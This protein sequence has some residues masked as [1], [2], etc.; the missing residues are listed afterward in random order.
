M[1]AR[2]R[3][4]HT[5]PWDL[6]PGDWCWNH[7][8][9][10]GK[11]EGPAERWLLYHSPNPHVRAFGMLDSRWTVTGDG[12]AITVSPSIHNN[13]GKGADGGEWHGFLTAGE[14]TSC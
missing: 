3:L 9:P 2:Q 7:V 14:W 6:A 12:E 4:D 11:P 1:R 10:H 8:N 5:D 13:P